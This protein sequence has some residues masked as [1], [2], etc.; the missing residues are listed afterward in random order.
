MSIA[1]NPF[2]Q[3]FKTTSYESVF[4]NLMKPSDAYMRR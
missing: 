1:T 3:I 4:F 2:I